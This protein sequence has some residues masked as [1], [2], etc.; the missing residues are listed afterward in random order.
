MSPSTLP[1]THPPAVRP[2][3]ARPSPTKPLSPPDRPL[4]CSHTA[5]Q[6]TYRNIPNPTPLPF[7]EWTTGTKRDYPSSI[8]TNDP[9]SL[10]PW[11][12][13]SLLPLHPLY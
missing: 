13:T 4:L 6:N 11:Y 3:L 10:P 9:H 12:V 2:P 7:Q 5:R 8:P 1:T